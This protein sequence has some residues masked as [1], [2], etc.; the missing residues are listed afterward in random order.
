MHDPDRTIAE[1]SA[2]F[3]LSPGQGFS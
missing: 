1:F 2:L 3:A